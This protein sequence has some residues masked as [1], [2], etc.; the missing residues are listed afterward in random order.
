MV[1]RNTGITY[2]I[3][4]F[5]VHSLFGSKQKCSLK[6]L[7]DA[8]CVILICY[9]AVTGMSGKFTSSG[10]GVRGGTS[11]GAGS[12]RG[13]GGGGA[14]A[15]GTKGGTGLAA[16]MSTESDISLAGADGVCV[17]AVFGCGEP[18]QNSMSELW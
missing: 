13:G 5:T 7:V 9:V 12:V 10:G 15:G 14:G 1:Y 11:G 8:L 3:A 17:R 6:Y 16:V 4:T 2:F 18:Q